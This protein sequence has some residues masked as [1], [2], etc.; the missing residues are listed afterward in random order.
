MDVPVS[1]SVLDKERIQQYASTDLTQIGNQ[2][3]GV[4]LARQGGGGS[5]AILSIRGVGNLASDYGTEQPIALVI[6]GMSLTRGHAIDLG[7]FDI[8]SV[9]VLKG[10]QSL[11]FGKN[12]PAGVI[13]ITS[14]NPGKAFGGYARASYEFKTR[15]PAVE[16]AVDLP[17]GGDLA[18]RLAGRYSNMTHGYFLNEALPIADPFPSELGTLPGAKNYRGPSTR[19]AVIRGTARWTPTTNFD[20]TLKANYSYYHD[21]AG[22]GT[23]ELVTCGAGVINPSSI[24]APGVVLT[25]P[26]GDCKGN[27][28]RSNGVPP[29]AVAQHFVGAPADNTPYNLSK[30]QL[31][32]LAMNYHVPN[33]TFSSVTGYFSQVSRD[34]DNFDFT[35]WAQ[36]VD[37][38]R[39]RNR[40]FTQELRA[41]SS[42]DFPVNFTVGGFY[43][44]ETLR[45]FNTAKIAPLG[46]FDGANPAGF[47]IFAPPPEE[48][49][50]AY[51]SATV[52]AYN[53]NHAWSVFGELSWKILDNLELAGGA[54]YT[55]ENHK[56]DI[57]NIFNRFD[58]LFGPIINP[59]SPQGVRYDPRVV[60]NNVSPEA[61]LTW[62]PVRN[63]T[64]YGAFKTGYLSGGAQNPGTLTNIFT[65]AGGTLTTRNRDGENDLLQYKSEK[66]R[67]GEVGLKFDGFVPGLSGDFTAFT[68]KYSQLQVVVFDPATTS[69]SL[70][71]AGAARDQGVEGNLSYRAMPDLTLRGSFTYSH[72]KYISYQGASCFNG[73][74]A[75]QGCVGGSQDLSG[76]RYGIAPFSWNLGVNY[77]RPVATDWTAALAADV[78]GYTRGFRVLREPGSANPGYRRVD[79]A[80]RLFQP[81]GPLEFALIGTNLFNKYYLLANAIQQPLGSPG[82]VY[83]LPGTPRQVTLQ[84][85]FRF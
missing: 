77:Q 15:T 10:P 46:A 19:S 65:S 83:N 48:Y 14:N 1:V 13:A 70:Q 59:L 23:N 30:T 69:F 75:A 53:R 49:I 84:G 36:A 60:S 71:N 25:D 64:L 72:L 57:G 17:A 79:A 74:T 31:H 26:F 81:D 3:T 12:S 66:V 9:Q 37:S 16:G 8:S 80:L 38:Q 32:T 28:K 82:S 6:D 52:T 35:V 24:P 21:N 47:T 22:T 5:G 33:I 39:V 55:H 44:R 68:Y 43:Q 7:Q 85:T 78:F 27:W 67:G 54:R 11:F 63:V 73:Q 40:N 56:T 50:G 76:T 20:A 62:H 18:F 58:Y 61:T 45:L 42:F 29:D 34:Y 4:S 51:N 2:I 41:V